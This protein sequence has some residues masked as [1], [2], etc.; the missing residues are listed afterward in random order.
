MGSNQ[1][2]DI[3]RSIIGHV[4][5]V[6]IGRSEAV[7]QILCCWVAGGHVLIEDIPGTGKTMM[8]RAIARTFNSTFKRIQFTP[9]L[10]PNDV[11]GFSIFEQKT[12]TFRFV[13]G[14]VFTSILLADEINRATPRTQSSLLEAM[15]ERQVSIEGKTHKLSPTFFVMATQNPLENQGTFPL[16]EAQLDRFTMKITLGYIAPELEINLLKSHNHQHPIDALQPLQDE[17]I[18]LQLRDLLPQVKVT[19]E[20]YQYAMRLVH[21]TRSHPD[22]RW[23][24]SPRAL[25]SLMKCA[26]A[27]ALLEGKNFVSPSQI[28]NLAIPVLHHRLTLSGEAKIQGKNTVDVLKVLLEKNKV[29][30][31]FAS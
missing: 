14:P 1:V 12:S 31:R 15:A 8:A 24:A 6:I 27:M 23:G 30:V 20:V 2:A 3:V 10:L 7:R 16:P 29:P 26:Q 4:E 11:L 9:D 22:L 28:Y 13:E 21:Q 25:L 17:S 18:I 5:Q 19:D